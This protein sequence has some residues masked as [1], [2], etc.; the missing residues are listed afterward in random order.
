MHGVCL[1]GPAVHV[2]KDTPPMTPPAVVPAAHARSLDTAVGS[3]GL[4]QH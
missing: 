3:A 1:C 2:E 4:A